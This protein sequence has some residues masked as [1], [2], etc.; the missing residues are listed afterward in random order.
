MRIFVDVVNRPTS[1]ED[2]TD[3][4]DSSHIVYLY[5]AL[6]EAKPLLDHSGQLSDPSALLSQHILGP[7]NST[8][9]NS[10]QTWKQTQF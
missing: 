6:W 7:G 4:D 8:T 3:V 1:A 5:A 2:A 9:D 10:K